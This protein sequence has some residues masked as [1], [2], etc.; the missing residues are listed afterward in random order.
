MIY[1]PRT[2]AEHDWLRNCFKTRGEIGLTEEAHILVWLRDHEPVWLVGY[3][4]WLGSTCQMHM[5]A[6]QPYIPKQLRF[7]AFNYAFNVIKR[8]RVFGLVNSRNPKA[9][10]LD[11]WFGFQPLVVVPGCHDDGGDLIVLTMTAEDWRN[12]Q[13]LRTNT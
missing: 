10:K 12:G 2:K 11:R 6:L 8:T 1:G 3:D 4:A 13:K 9:L 7:A 5:L